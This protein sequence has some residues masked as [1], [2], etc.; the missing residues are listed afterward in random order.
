MNTSDPKELPVVIIKTQPG[1]RFLDIKELIEYRDLFVFMIWRSIKVLYAQT[2]MGFAWAIFN[3][4][5]Q[6]IVFTV[7]FGRIAKIPTEGI[8]YVLFAAVG[9]IP[10]TYM[11]EAT[12]QSSQS[13]VTGQ[14]MLGKVYFPRLIFPFTPVFAKLLDFIIS[15]VIIAILMVWYRVPITVNLLYFP[16]FLLLMICVPLA[17]GL[18]LSALAIR[19]RDVKYAIPLIVRM[20]M[21]SAPIVYSA[22][23]VPEKYRLVYSLNPIVGVI[24]GLR[25]S[26][27]GLPIPWMFIWPGTVVSLIMLI[28]GIFYFHYMEKIFVDVI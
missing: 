7:V 27:L 16:F 21:Y 18:W 26:L 4:L 15:L 3:P 10:W 22:S 13:L 12:I 19:F 25:A 20:L 6:L 17:A 5:I 9:L 1:L 8:P 28:V 14:Q 11:S 23:T 2:I 24:E